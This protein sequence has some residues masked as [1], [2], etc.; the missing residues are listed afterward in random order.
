MGVTVVHQLINRKTNISDTP[1]TIVDGVFFAMQVD[2][3]EISFYELIKKPRKI[4]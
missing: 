2:K 4:S 1:L 3:L